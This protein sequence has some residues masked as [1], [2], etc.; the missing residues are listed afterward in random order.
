MVTV[1]AH[2]VLMVNE[3]VVDVALWNEFRQY[4]AVLG[5]YGANSFQLRLLL[6]IYPYPVPFFH[7]PSYIF[8]KKLEVF[9]EGWLRAYVE[10]HGLFI[11]TGQR[12]VSI[13]LSEISKTFKKRSLPVHVRRIQPE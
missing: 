1:A 12:Y 2:L 3:T 10:S 11:L 8:C 6:T 9:I 13:Y 5:Q 4:A 7:L